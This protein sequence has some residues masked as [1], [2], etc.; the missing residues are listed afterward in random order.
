MK[1]RI[2]EILQ[3]SVKKRYNE[4][5]RQSLYETYYRKGRILIALHETPMDFQ[6]IKHLPQE[7]IH[8]YFDGIRDELLYERR[9]SY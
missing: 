2:E 5:Y 7:S 3:N 8:G 1:K 6:E 9:I 4:V